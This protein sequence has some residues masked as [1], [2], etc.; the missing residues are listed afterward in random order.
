[1]L[2]E[3]VLT[4][5]S[6]LHFDSQPHSVGTV[7]TFNCGRGWYVSR[8]VVTMCF[9]DGSWSTTTMPTCQAGG[10]WGWA[11]FLEYHHHANTSGGR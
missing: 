4:S 11:G 2:I 1:M 10:M 3:Y 9:P 6:L 7:V 5:S 8:D